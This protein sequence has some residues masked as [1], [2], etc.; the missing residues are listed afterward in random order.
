MAPDYR[1]LH[2]CELFTEQ[3]WEIGVEK[4]G[5]WG[6][7]RENFCGRYLADVKHFHHELNK[8]LKLNYL[9]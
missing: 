6:K 7:K 1:H 9:I 8:C 3:K 4:E 5:D 2:T